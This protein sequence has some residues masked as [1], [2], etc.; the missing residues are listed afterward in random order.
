MD[1]TPMEILAKIVEAESSARS[2]FDEVAALRE[3]F[4]NYVNE[5]I[6]ALRKQYFAQAE[7]A[8]AHA[9]ESEAARADAE[10]AALNAEFERALAAL[11][12]YYEKEQESI[13]TRIFE[14]AVAANA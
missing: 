2:V 12:A 3:G 13:V 7:D 6:E 1:M 14:L 4:D 9:R 11:K 5:H 10:I 8:I